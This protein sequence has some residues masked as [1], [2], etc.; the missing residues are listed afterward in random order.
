M[1]IGPMTSAVENADDLIER[2]RRVLATEAEA[3]A[4]L[5]E[6]YFTK[7]QAQH[8]EESHSPSS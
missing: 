1:K 5:K 2:G 3:V 4:A 6:A 7:E 8:V